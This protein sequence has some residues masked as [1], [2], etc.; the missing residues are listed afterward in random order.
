MLIPPFLQLAMFTIF[1]LR[2]TSGWGQYNG[3]FS[4]L[5]SAKSKCP[6][7]F[8]RRECKRC[9]VF[10]SPPKH[11]QNMT[12]YEEGIQRRI[13]GKEVHVTNNG[14][15]RPRKHLIPSVVKRKHYRASLN[16]HLRRVPDHSSFRHITEHRKQILRYLNTARKRCHKC[17]YFLYSKGRVVKLARNWLFSEV[18]HR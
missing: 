12:E 5:K 3:Q 11:V 15:S 16:W 13:C 1:L 4:K 18:P 14:T 17:S 10:S 7:C 8:Q 2:Q 6:V 9:V